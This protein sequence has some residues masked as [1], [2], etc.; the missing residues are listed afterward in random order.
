MRTDQLV[1]REQDLGFV[2]EGSVR[3][4][5]LLFV[6]LWV[7]SDV[8]LCVPIVTLVGDNS[9]ARLCLL[10]ETGSSRD[11]LLHVLTMY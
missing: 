7:N 4:P 5:M 10:C 2:F 9:L 1:A 8:T 6:I 11:I 3:A